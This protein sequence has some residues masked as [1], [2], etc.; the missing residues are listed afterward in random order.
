MVTIKVKINGSEVKTIDFQKEIDVKDLL[1][2]LGMPV[3]INVV[4]YRGL[5]LP[6]NY[7]FKKDMEVDVITIFSGG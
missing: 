3:N 2:N 5:P 4:I 1:N 7:V 6:E